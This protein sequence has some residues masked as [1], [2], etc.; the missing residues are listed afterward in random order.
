MP[1]W[2]NAAGYRYAGAVIFFI[3]LQWLAAIGRVI[4]RVFY[5][6]KFGWDDVALIVTLVSTALTSRCC[7]S[8]TPGIN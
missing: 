5:V 7:V 8:E 4:V 2:Y 3:I 6:K 1:V